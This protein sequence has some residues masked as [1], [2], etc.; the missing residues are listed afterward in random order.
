MDIGKLDKR[1]EI[2]SPTSSISSFGQAIVLPASCVEVWAQ[3]TDVVRA[4]SEL[5]N[6][7]MQEQT[8][9]VSRFV[10]R[11]RSGINGKMWVKCDGSYFAITQI[12]EIGRRKY[13]EIIGVKDET[14]NY[15]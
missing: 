8:K 2:C 7:A 3:K 5:E 4:V 10:I 9:Y 1:I 12:A 15:D 6:E 13:L 14:D 11:W